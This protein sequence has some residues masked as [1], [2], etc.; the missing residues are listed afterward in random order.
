MDSRN[1]ALEAS[2]EVADRS[3]T[4]QERR[5][6]SQIVS[7]Y[8]QERALGYCEICGYS[9]PFERPDGTP[10]LESHH[11][12]QLADD[13]PDAPQ[14]VVAA[15]PTCHRR[16]HHGADKDTINMAAHERIQSVEAAIEESR[17]IVVT[18]AIIR[19]PEGKV[20][21]AQ[22]MH[23]Q[24]LGSKWE[25]PGG[26]VHQGETLE[27][28]L[29]REISE[30]LGVD[31]SEQRRFFMV[32]HKYPTF[33]IRL[34]SIIAAV[35]DNSFQLNAHEEIKWVDPKELLSMD[36]APADNII[37]RALGEPHFR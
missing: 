12:T 29:K 32:D 17:L 37:A 33:D 23:S 25:F 14:D 5:R 11:I 36:L 21:L 34:C 35:D 19:N 20:L 8:V 4:S 22:R 26:K 16:V 9:A 15:C 10:Y 24:E 2:Q 13:G 31:I 30:E 6:R 27:E 3:K 1:G 28:C 7:N 18:A